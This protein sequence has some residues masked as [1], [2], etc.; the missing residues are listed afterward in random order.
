MLTMT[1]VIPFTARRMQEQ[2]AVSPD[3]EE[4]AALAA[5]LV[6]LIAQVRDVAGQTTALGAPALQMERTAQ[7]LL[8]AVSALECAIEALAEDGEQVPV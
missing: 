7:H 2:P 6:D 1:N 4:R 5:A 8:D 3:D